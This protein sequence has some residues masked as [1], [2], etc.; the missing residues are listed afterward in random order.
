[1]KKEKAP[2]GRCVFFHE[3]KIF[4]AYTIE[5]SFW[6]MSQ[7]DKIKEDETVHSFLGIDF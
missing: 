7:N 6:S 3:F 2:A 5:A 1:M 4:F